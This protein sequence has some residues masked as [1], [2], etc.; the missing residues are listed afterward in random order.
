MSNRGYLSH[1]DHS[2]LGNVATYQKC[3]TFINRLFSTVIAEFRKVPQTE[4]SHL[5]RD[6][7]DSQYM[8]C[9]LDRKPLHLHTIA[10]GFLGPC[11]ITCLKKHS[12]RPP[13]EKPQWKIAF[14]W[15]SSL[16]Q[17]GKLTPKRS[18]SSQL[19]THCCQNLSQKDMDTKW[20]CPGQAA[21]VK[22]GAGVVEGNSESNKK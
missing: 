3:R 7:P 10:L 22:K 16:S 12:D 4:L 18:K 14:K 2:Q 1:L 5:S 21:I 17:R 8:I 11:S 15:N 19:E 20:K 13:V 6:T 9:V